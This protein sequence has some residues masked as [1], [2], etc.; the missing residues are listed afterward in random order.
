[1]AALL[2]VEG[3]RCELVMRMRMVVLEWRCLLALWHH[4]H[5]VT[6]RCHGVATGDHSWVVVLV[7]V[8]S[9]C[10]FGSLHEESRAKG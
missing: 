7:M 3:R 10:L 4:L 9:H 2:V 8:M 1:M 5:H 6:H